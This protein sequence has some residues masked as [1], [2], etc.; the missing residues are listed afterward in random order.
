MQAYRE[1]DIRTHFAGSKQL[2]D[3]LEAFRASIEMN[4]DPH[5]HLRSDDVDDDDRYAEAAALVATAEN[6]T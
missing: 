2:D 6:E 1:Q 3:A 4:H 5:R